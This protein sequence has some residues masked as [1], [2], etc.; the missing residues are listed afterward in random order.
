MDSPWH[1]WIFAMHLSLFWTPTFPG[2]CAPLPYLQQA[3]QMSIFPKPVAKM[4]KEEEGLRL[5]ASLLPPALF[6]LSNCA[7]QFGGMG[8][9]PPAPSALEQ[10]H[11]LLT[12]LLPMSNSSP[13][14]S[15]YPATLFT[16]GW[17]QLHGSILYFLPCVSSHIPSRSPESCSMAS[18]ASLEDNH[19]P[20][21]YSV[22]LHLARQ[23]R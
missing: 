7:Y 3:S 4:A 21:D 15:F 8:R 19:L 23:C 10:H 1:I 13:V 12:L 22:E 9:E 6:L 20:V 16:G 11:C 14:L 18:L 2:S 5:R 17:G